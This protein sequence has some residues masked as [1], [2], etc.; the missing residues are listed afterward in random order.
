MWSFALYIL[1]SETV[2]P[3]QLDRGARSTLAQ[4]GNG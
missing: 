3:Q 1:E 4:R 2:M